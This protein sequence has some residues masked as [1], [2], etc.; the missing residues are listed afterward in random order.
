MTTAKITDIKPPKPFLSRLK[1]FV[2]SNS[3]WEGFVEA[4][5]YEI[6][7][8]RKQLEQSKDLIE[9]YQAQGAIFALRRLKYLR[10]QVH[11]K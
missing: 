4:L 9:I 6:E 11:A 1:G 3:Q 7:M 10:D 5:E 2:D 8:Q